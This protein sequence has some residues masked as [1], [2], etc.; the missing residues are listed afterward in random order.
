MTITD[1]VEKSLKR[2]KSDEQHWA[3]R[4]FML[5]LLQLGV[6]PDS[7]EQFTALKPVLAQI[8]AD[9]SASPSARAAVSISTWSFCTLFRYT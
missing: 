6:C 5:L 4:C 3:S 1:S 9:P 8:M 2:G 7:E